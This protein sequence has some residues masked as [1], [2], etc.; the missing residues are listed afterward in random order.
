MWAE[1]CPR[2]FQNLHNLLAN[3]ALQL[4]GLRQ[5]L[6]DHRGVRQASGGGLPSTGYLQ[7]PP[8]QV[9]H[10]QRDGVQTSRASQSHLHQMRALPAGY[11]AWRHLQASA[12]LRQAA[13][14]QVRSLSLRPSLWLHDARPRDAHARQRKRQLC[15]DN[16]GTTLRRLQKTL[17]HVS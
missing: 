5:G 4:Q 7:L 3:D 2:L 14:I 1:L 13:E 16:G 12:D 6:P 10:Q 17:S 8:V 15:A 9:L 11:Q